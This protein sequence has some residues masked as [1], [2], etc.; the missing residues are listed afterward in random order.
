MLAYPLQVPHVVLRYRE[1]G[2]GKQPAPRLAGKT[3]ERREPRVVGLPGVHIEFSSRLALRSLLVSN[4]S[5]RLC[6]PKPW[7]FFNMRHELFEGVSECLGAVVR[8]YF[9]AAYRCIHY[10]VHL[11]NYKDP[12]QS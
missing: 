6:A 4:P 9:V 1:R 2:S 3:Y 5:S 11:P 7:K 10:V 8:I 12:W